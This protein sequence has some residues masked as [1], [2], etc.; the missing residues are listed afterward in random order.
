[1][2]VGHVTQLWDAAS[3]LRKSHIHPARILAD[4]AEEEAAKFMILIDAVRCPRHPCKR[5][6][7]QLG[8]FN[9][10]LAK[11]LYARAYERR[12]T[13]F[14]QL[15]EFVNVDRG[16]FYLDGPND[17][18]WIFRN[19]VLEERERKL[20]VDYIAHDDGHRWS[21]PS[22]IVIDHLL[23]MPRTVSTM[24]HFRDAGILTG[25]ALAAISELWR[26]VKIDSDTQYEEIVY[27][28]RS[29]VARMEL[30][31]LLQKQP[32]SAHLMLI[33]E[34]SFPM[35]DLDL[36]PVKTDLK[37]LRERQSSQLPDL[38]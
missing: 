16:Q 36:S 26:N 33:H 7:D 9:D 8:R 4:I 28:N 15:Q 37:K 5:L 3:A 11:G 27:H 18:D 14:A 6:S 10:H 2:I 38:C 35:Y 29:T 13:T 21:N 22:G 34:W 20:Y 32:S 12:P 23:P 19:Y 25:E 30:R 17:I 24:F 31:G 1:M